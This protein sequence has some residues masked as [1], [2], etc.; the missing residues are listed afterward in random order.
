MIHAP[1]ARPSDPVRVV[2]EDVPE[3]VER[4]RAA[5]RRAAATARAVELVHP[6]LTEGGRHARARVMR[7]M[8]EALDVV[9]SAAP[10]VEV[11]VGGPVEIPQPRS[12]P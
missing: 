11:R 2:V 9:R 8:D 4:V 7:R 6:V 3:L 5:A 10:G 12:A 1:S